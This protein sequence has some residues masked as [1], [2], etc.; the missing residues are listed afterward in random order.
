M[1]LT[2]TQLAA[3]L[4]CPHLTQL[5]RQRREGLVRIDFHPDPRLEALRERGL[6]HETAYVETLRREGRTVCDLR[7]ERD[8]AVTRRAMER[9]FDVIVQ[10]ALR[11][12]VFSG[13]ADVL[14][15]VDA[16]T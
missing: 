10:A 8:P 1:H 6:Q 9:G 7:D 14:L 16:T 12:E 13:I 4:A 2:P 15:R 5:E 3:H 11:D